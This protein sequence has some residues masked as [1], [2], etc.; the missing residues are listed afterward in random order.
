MKIYIRILVLIPLFFIAEAQATIYKCVKKNAD[1]Y[2]ND[3]PCPVSDKE[4]Q[5][6]SVKDPIGGYIPPKYVS[7]KE[8]VSSK[9]VVIGSTVKENNIK[10][11]KGLS[12]GSTNGSSA[13]SD[14]G[15]S[16]TESNS[17]SS[18]NSVNISSG[19]SSQGR[20]RLN[21]NSSEVKGSADYP[22]KN[23]IVYD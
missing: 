1:V 10:K 20:S 12:E 2:Y 14:G 11:K 21:N 18:T 16:G 9:G 7:K 6:K 5:L 19:G 13:G 17:Q 3:K 15:G 4:S 22:V 8:G 23:V